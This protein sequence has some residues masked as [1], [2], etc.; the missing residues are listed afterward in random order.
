MSPGWTLS[1]LKSLWWNRTLRDLRN[2]LSLD[3]PRSRGGPLSVW[4]IGI[5]GSN[6]CSMLCSLFQIMNNFW[7]PLYPRC[8]KSVSYTHF[9]GHV[10]GCGGRGVMVQRLGAG[11]VEPERQRRREPFVA[12]R[13][14]AR[15]QSLM[16][17]DLGE[18]GGARQCNIHVFSSWCTSLS[19]IFPGLVLLE[20]ISLHFQDCQIHIFLPYFHQGF[21]KANH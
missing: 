15:I 10:L 16:E 20:H 7:D 8:G 17:L 12:A 9:P 1:V 4:E 19:I 18:Q 3:A 6:F 14:R 13:G 21:Q 2:P 5:L 11:L